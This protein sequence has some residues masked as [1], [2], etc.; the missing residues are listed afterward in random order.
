MTVVINHAPKWSHARGNTVVPSRWQATIRTLNPSMVPIEV[1]LGVSRCHNLEHRNVE[2]GHS[3]EKLLRVHPAI[4]YWPTD[5][6]AYCDRDADG[7]VA[8]LLRPELSVLK[9]E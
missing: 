9:A 6:I 3:R 5:L 1:M 2:Q 4:A 8:Q 7:F